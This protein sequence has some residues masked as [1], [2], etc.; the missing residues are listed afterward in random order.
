MV[1]VSE[2]STAKE[3]VKYREGSLCWLKVGKRGK[4][5]WKA[6]V[7]VGQAKVEALTGKAVVM[8]NSGT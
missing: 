1:W 8:V 4:F 5:D 3:F 6:V 2:S 7:S